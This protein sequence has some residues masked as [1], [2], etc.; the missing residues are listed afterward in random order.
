MG[1]IQTN[2]VTNSNLAVWGS[3]VQGAEYTINGQRVDFQDL[4]VAITE[5]RAATI[6]KEVEP[7][8]DRMRNRNKHLENL[9]T[10]LSD[11][12]GIEA[13]FK[14]EDEGSTT[15]SSSL[16]NTTLAVLNFLQ[17][18]LYTSDGKITKSNCEKGIQLIKTEIDKANNESSADMTRL[19]SLV[20]RRDE[21]YQTATSLMQ[22]IGDCR[23]S[24]V[25]NF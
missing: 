3:N 9:G 2:E 11:L 23:S 4:M 8:S 14:N 17:T 12:S 19:Q 13:G 24:V 18:G 15:S 16:G 21:S 5:Q 7:M 20:D 10:A 22:A 25:K 6:E 1:V